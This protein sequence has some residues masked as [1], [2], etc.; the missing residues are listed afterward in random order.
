MDDTEDIDRYA[1]VGNRLLELAL[2]ER[3]SLSLI[4]TVRRELAA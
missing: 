1:Q 4:N 2:P 3:E